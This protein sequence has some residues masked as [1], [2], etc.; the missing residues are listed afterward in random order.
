MKRIEIYNENLTPN[1][2]LCKRLKTVNIDEKKSSLEH[3]IIKPSIYKDFCVDE[4]IESENIIYE[5]VDNKNTELELN[6]L[7][8]QYNNLNEELINTYNQLKNKNIENEE[9][10]KLVS[11][12]EKSVDSILKTKK[13][14]MEEQNLK[15]LMVLKSSYTKYILNISRQIDNLQQSLK[16]S[17]TTC[18]L[19]KSQFDEI[20]NK[21][22]EQQKE[23]IDLKKVLV[24]GQN[25][26]SEIEKK[27]IRKEQQYQELKKVIRKTNE[28]FENRMLTAKKM[29]ED[30]KM[31][32]KTFNE[33]LN[34]KTGEL[35]TLQSECEKTKKELQEIKLKYNEDSTNNSKLLE[36]NK[37]LNFDYNNIKTNYDKLVEENK[38]FIQQSAL[39]KG[40]LA[41]QIRLLK[42]GTNNEINSLKKENSDL[43]VKLFDLTSKNSP[44]NNKELEKLKNENKQYRNKIN[45]LQ[46]SNEELLSYVE[47][48]L[49]SQ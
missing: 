43:K 29:W 2:N 12:M 14:E 35:N 26:F 38:K 41:E 23:I 7:K 37:K 15:S 47:Q 46:H 27:Y 42:N 3:V 32:V 34:Q 6:L 36:V 39:E 40:D 17:E 8:E 4:V 11:E 19:W 16:A 31:K 33:Q 30:E 21:F 48:L 24:N 22:K 13:R 10:L 18:Q 25:E 1:C 49:P 28:D 45:E 44:I 9:L 20:Q 5:K